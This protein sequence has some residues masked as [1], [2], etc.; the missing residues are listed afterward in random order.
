M[1]THAARCH[2]G[3]VS[4]K[5]R[6]GSIRKKFGRFNGLPQTKLRIP[7]SQINIALPLLPLLPIY[8]F[9][10]L[11]I[12]PLLVSARPG[13][14]SAVARA[15]EA[16]KVFKNMRREFRGFFFMR[17]GIKQLIAKTKVKHFKMNCQ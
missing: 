8:P 6:K 3:I 2:T 13:V 7:V 1:N 16:P 15:A 5:L 17:E 14:D 4:K 11:P 12:Y 10:I 9:T